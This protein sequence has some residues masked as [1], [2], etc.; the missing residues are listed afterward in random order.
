MIEYFIVFV[1]GLVIGSF[2]NVCIYRIPKG[3]SIVSPPSSCPE[4]G[5][6]IKWYDNIP[7]ISYVLLKGRCRSC[8]SKISLRYP[9]VELLTATLI[10]LIF[11]RYGITFEA[12]YFSILTAFLIVVSFIDIDTMEVPV[13]LCYFSMLVGLLLSPFSHSITFLDSV[14]GASFGAGVILF[15]IETYYVITG[16]E[17]MGYGD[18]NIMAVVG[19]FL[20]WKEVLLTLFLA[21]FVGALIG[22]A[23]MVAKGKDRKFAVPFGPFLSIGAYV[24]LL[25]GKEMIAWY[26]GGMGL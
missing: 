5:E 17:G 11:W 9:L 23:L 21:S 20:G 1:L 14:L 8:G 26:L 4:C 25:F 22:I 16:R 7:L 24:S 18:A 15:V 6:R 3:K 13:K 19:A 12:L 10:T 2:L